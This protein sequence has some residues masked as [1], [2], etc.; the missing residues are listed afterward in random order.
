MSELTTQLKIPCSYYNKNV[1]RSCGLIE[2]S[3]EEQLKIKLTHLKDIFSKENL[4]TNGLRPF[5]PSD[6]QLSSRNKAKLVVNGSTTEPILGITGSN[7]ETTR[8]DNCPLHNP[9]LNAVAQTVTRLIQTYKVSPYDIS[10][11]IGELKFLLLRI[12]NETDQILARFVLRSKTEIPKIQKL[13]A[14]LMLTHKNVALISVNIQPVHQAI[15]EGPEEIHLLGEPY[16][17]EKLG[18]YKFATSPQSFSQVTS[19]VAVKLYTRVSEMIKDNRPGTVL[20]LFSG[21]GCFSIFTSPY[22]KKCI[23]VEISPSSVN[24]AQSSLKL[25]QISN[26]TF[27]EQDVLPF[28][29]QHKESPDLLI[30]NPPRRGLKADICN[31]L[32]RLKPKTIIYSS[33]NPQTLAQDL[34]I[35]SDYEILSIEPFDM[36]PMTEHFE[37]VVKLNLR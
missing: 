3:Y 4:S 27:L 35:L 11:R 12:A 18:P 1:C 17:I 2:H 36:F 22:F 15:I 5:V 20:D 25:N 14:E 29:K 33:C 19:N 21:S 8:I 28:L 13:G 24:D 30:V 23:G 32:V 6:T 34:K 37:V 10:K 16:L 9:K 7:Q 31:E 26:I